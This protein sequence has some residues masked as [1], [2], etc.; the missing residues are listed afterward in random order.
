MSRRAFLCSIFVLALGTFSTG[1]LTS[2]DL[3]AKKGQEDFTSYRGQFVIAS[4]KMPDARFQKTVI[5]LVRH[6]EDG[7]MGIVINRPVREAPLSYLM[8]GF[9]VPG[10]EAAR[11]N[12]LL[13]RGGP[14]EPANAYVL[15]SAE[16]SRGNT[17]KIS[18]D[19]AMSAASVVLQDLAR[20]KGPKQV[21]F[22][23]GYSGW[24]PGQLENEISRGGWI[25]TPADPKLIFGPNADTK[26]ERA[27]K[28]EGVEL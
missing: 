7:A 9:R 12:L 11:G 22:A 8:Q 24:G 15:H 13:H 4:P 18:K 3:S 14:V 28:G 20:K 21:L 16:Y 2:G 23:F 27:R 10:H 5:F 19:I 1:L 26:W 17:M 25:I 6:D